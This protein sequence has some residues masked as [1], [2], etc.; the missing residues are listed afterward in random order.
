MTNPYAI[1]GVSPHAPLEEIK[2][3]WKR[4]AL[5]FHPDRNPSPDAT[6]RFRAIQ[7]AWEGLRDDRAGV[8]A[9]LIAEAERARWQA[10]EQIRLAAQRQAFLNR[11]A[12]TAMDAELHQEMA[13]CPRRDLYDVRFYGEPVTPPRAQ[14]PVRW[15]VENGRTAV[16]DLLNLLMG[17]VGDAPSEATGCVARRVGPLWGHQG[18]STTLLSGVNRRP[19]LLLLPSVRLRSPMHP[20]HR[21]RRSAADPL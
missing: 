18:Q 13:A 7:Q 16:W 5:A 20:P 11:M 12:Q 2:L 6:T 19:V 14:A 21:A 9:R 4:Q 3:A 8:D 17:E 10:A 15:R 1:L